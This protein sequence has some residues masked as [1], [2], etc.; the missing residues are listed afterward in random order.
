MFLTPAFR[1]FVAN[2]ATTHFGVNVTN[3]PLFNGF[4]VFIKVNNAMLSPTSIST[5]GVIFASPLEDINCV[6]AGAGITLGNPGNLGCTPQDGPGIAHEEVLCNGCFAQGSG[7]LFNVT[8]TGAV[9][10][11]GTSVVDVY[12]DQILN[13]TPTFVAHLTTSGFYGSSATPQD[14][15]IAASPFSQNVPQG[16][17]GSVVITLT[18][19][20]SFAGTVTLNTRTFPAALNTVTSLNVSSVALTA[21]GVKHVGATIS[22]TPSTPGGGY[23]LVLNSTAT[24]VIAIIH[25]TS[26]SVTVTIPD[27]S[28]VPS[29][30]KLFVPLGS[31]N[32]SILTLTSVNSFAGVVTLSTTIFPSLVNGPTITL[33]NSS[34]TGS[35][36]RVTLTAGGTN[37]ATLTVSSSATTAVNSYSITVT[38]ASG[39]LSRTASV[40][41]SVVPFTIGANPVSLSMMRGSFQSSNITLGSVSNVASNVTLTAVVS[42]SVTSPPTVVFKNSTFT[43]GRVIVKVPPGGTNFAI[44]NVTTTST[45]TTGNYTILVTGTTGTASRTVQVN[46][47]VEAPFTMKTLPSSITLSAGTNTTSTIVLGNIVTYPVNVTL[48][49]AIAPSVGHGPTVSLSNATRTMQLRVWVIVP[50]GGTSM[51]TLNINT[52]SLTPPGAYTLTVSGANGSAT[53][54]A[55]VLLSVAPFTEGA[56]P[57]SLNISQ[58]SFGT[59]TITLKSINNFVGSVNVTA[60]VSP[61]A[62]NGPTTSLS[63][64]TKTGL[65]SVTVKLVAGG[66][67]VA[68]LNVST[69]ALTP[70]G[71]YVVGVTG[72]TVVNGVPLS[73]TANVTVTVTLATP[74]F[75]ISAQPPSLTVQ[76]GSFVISGLTLRSILGFA[77]NVNITSSVTPVLSNGPVPLLN[78]STKTG[79][80]NVMVSLTPGGTNTATLN[81]TTFSSTPLQAYTVNVTGKS[82][83]L[84]HFVLVTVNVVDFSITPS[85]TSISISYATASFGTSDLT[86]GSLNGFGGNVTLTTSISPVTT[87]GPIAVLNNSTETGLSS[88]IVKVVAGG[89]GTGTLNVTITA[90]TPGGVYSVTVIGS[91]GGL[92]HSVLVGVTV[93]ADFRISASP[94]SLNIV[95]GGFSTSSIALDSFGLSG[96]VNVTATVSPLGTGLSLSLENSTFTGPSIVV[97]LSLGGTNSASLNVTTTTST[98]AGSY[99]VTV[100][101]TNSSLSRSTIVIVTVSPVGVFTA[102]TIS[103]ITV[104]P[105]GTATVGQKVT[106]TVTVVNSGSVTANFTLRVKWGSVTVV[107][108]NETLPPGQQSYPLSWDTTGTGAATDT[109]SAVIFQ[110]GA[111]SNSSTGPSY[112]LSPAGATFFNTET[113]AVIG[114]VAAAVA[115]LSLFLFLRRRRTMPAP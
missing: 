74:D 69:V 5:A 18:S 33:S 31:T 82:G 83:S 100:T 113:L 45:T 85:E 96:K 50:A 75:T 17:S 58:G 42:P 39:S 55:R 44:L 63:N 106:V 12:N 110:D 97:T 98:S 91:S 49:T 73:L 60:S 59:S 70:L 38:G 23:D 92:T 14:F 86:L 79:L 48:T 20:N 115:L 88:V 9:N 61:V 95:A 6:N 13:G 101:G 76:A 64:S 80:A 87:N 32:T 40:S 11:G 109:I 51:A 10:S 108:Q 84:E 43:G 99:T 29:P 65:S 66:T 47:T 89:T 16:T 53:V 15:T 4:N 107:E 1:P 30:N 112:T 72:R 57:S 46:A 27:F 114:G 35:S 8:F 2:R 56:S 37:T 24:A 7:L 105:T 68:S 81:V 103:A 104:S 62:L 26:V 77:G 90:A 71:S 54:S 19:V 22:P 67:G 41:V 52:T 94:G 34:F 111:W 25:D 3:M 21:G 93:T 28:I 78:N 102:P 36:V